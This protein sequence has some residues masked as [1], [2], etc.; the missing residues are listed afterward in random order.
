MYVL[1]VSHQ[2][3]YAAWLVAEWLRDFKGP[4]QLRLLVFLWGHSPPQLL[5][6]FFN[7]AKVIPDFILLVECNYLPLSQSAACQF[8]QRTAIL[9]SC[10]Y[11]H[12]SISSRIR[13]WSLPLTWIHNWSGHWISFPSVSSPILSLQF[14]QTET[15]LDELSYECKIS[16]ALLSK[17]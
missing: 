5:P 4:G 1:G 15:I 3:V 11:A 17:N 10:P 9:G 2:I 12:H 13:P 7:S 16:S 14:F 8:S 6:A